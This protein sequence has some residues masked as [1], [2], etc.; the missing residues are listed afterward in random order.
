M[1]DKYLV[2]VDKK[3]NRL[4]IEIYVFDLGLKEIVADEIFKKAQQLE[5]G[6]GCISNLSYIEF[7]LTSEILDIFETQMSFLKQLGMGQLVRVL[8]ESQ[9]PFHEELKKRSMEIAGYEGLKAGS[10]EEAEAILDLVQK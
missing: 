1:S 10:V 7:E 4:F 5:A 2:S 8:N 9:L 3:K 6:W